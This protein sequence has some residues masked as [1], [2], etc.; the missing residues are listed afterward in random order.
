ML[1]GAE[2]L[3][4][5]EFTA[6]ENR[7]R[8][9]TGKTPDEGIERADRV[10]C[11]GS[12]PAGGAEH[13]ARQ[14]RRARLVH[15]VKSSGEAALAG[16]EV[17]PA[18]ENLR[19]Q[20]GGHRPRLAGEG[21]SHI[22]SAGRVA[23]GHDLNRANRLRP[24]CL[25]GVECILG[26]GGAR[27]DLRHVEVAREALLFARVGEFRILLVDIECL[28]CVS[29]LLRGLDG[30]EVRARH[31]SGQR[32]PGKFVVGFQRGAFSLGGSFFRA[33][34]PPHV[35]LPCSAGGDA[36]YPTL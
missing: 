9:P 11:R 33:N 16:D 19:R 30:R 10:E 14:A 20:T 6:K 27:L 23:T 34:A 28:L 13:K 17:R 25:C 29:F 12:E 31:G 3:G 36:I 18:F 4:S 32:L 15:P 2:I 5:L 1:G 35:G 22:K 21:T 8:D 26:G 7:L 24:R